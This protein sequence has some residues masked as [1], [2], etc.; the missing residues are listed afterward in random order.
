MAQ[1]LSCAAFTLSA[2]KEREAGKKMVLSHKAG[3]AGGCKCKAGG[4]RIFNSFYICT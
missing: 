4:V 1:L 3:R 2:N